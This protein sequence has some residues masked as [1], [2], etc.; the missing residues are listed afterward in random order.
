NCSPPFDR[1]RRA[2]AP[3]NAR[4]ARR[5]ERILLIL[6]LLAAA[7]SRLCAQSPAFAGN[8][9]HT[10]VYPVRA[11]HMNRGLWS[12][13]VDATHT[14]TSSHYGEPLIT[15]SNTVIVPTVVA[16]IFNY[17]IKAYEGGTGRL[18]YTLTNDYR[19]LRNSS[20]WRPVYQPVLAASPSGLRLYYPGAGGTV[21]YVENPDSDTP[22]APVQFCFYT[23]LA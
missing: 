21:Y 5:A 8:A 23:N 4:L 13:S 6:A 3:L 7:T 16:S 17:S 19:V 12:N 20:G 9:Q 2:R 18:K 1:V 10:A 14:A 11:Q 15:P 22:S